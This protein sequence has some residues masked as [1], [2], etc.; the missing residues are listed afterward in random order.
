MFYLCIKFVFIINL[1]GFNNYDGE[2]YNINVDIFVYFIVV[3]LEVFIYVF[4]N[5][6]GVL[7]NDVVIF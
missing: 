6:V 4:S 7:I 3:L 1:I 5:I 2:F